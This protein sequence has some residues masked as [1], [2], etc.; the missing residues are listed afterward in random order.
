VAVVIYVSPPLSSGS[1]YGS[2]QQMTMGGFY[3]YVVVVL[4]CVTHLTNYCVCLF[5]AFATLLYHTD[6]VPEAMAMA[7]RGPDEVGG[8]E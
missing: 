5:Q 6:A 7:G 4:S 1:A 3:I 8:Y 2:A